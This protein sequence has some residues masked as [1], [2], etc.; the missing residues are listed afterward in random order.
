MASIHQ[1]TVKGIRGGEIDFSSF[2]GKKI[3]VVNVA[4]EC[5]LTPQYA[6][7][8]DMSVEFADNLVVVGFPANNFGAQEPGSNEEIQAFCSTKFGVSFPMAAKI[9]V[10]GDDIHALYKW[11]TQKGLN[12][13]QD[14]EVTWNFQKYLLD[15][16]GELLKVYEPS[17][18]PASEE[19]LQAILN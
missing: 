15:E 10:K 9:S 8:Q 4:S 7:L 2:A 1:F 14:S 11:L 3:L 17:M 5:G 6:Q 18:E 13:V 12:G 16:K 19:I